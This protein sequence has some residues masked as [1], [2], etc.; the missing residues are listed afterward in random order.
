M[1]DVWLLVQLPPHDCGAGNIVCKALLLP[2]SN[3][4]VG[5]AGIGNNACSCENVKCK[6]MALAVA[7]EHALSLQTAVVLTCAVMTSLW[8]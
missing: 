6:I 2:F 5:N 7:A 4:A 3:E 8:L 1:Q